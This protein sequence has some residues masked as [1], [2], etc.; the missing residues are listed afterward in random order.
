MT[1]AIPFL[2]TISPA[3]VEDEPLLLQIQSG[4]LQAHA[5]MELP[6]SLRRLGQRMLNE[7]L[8]LDAEELDTIGR[9]LGRALFI[10]RVRDLLLECAKVVAQNEQ[11][12]QIQL[13]INKPEIAALPWEYMT[14]GAA[15]PW[16]PALRDDYTLVRIGRQSP[17]PAPISVVGPL[18]ILA[19]GGPGQ[20]EQLAE[21]RAAL[22]D[23]IQERLISLR[24]LADTD[25]EEVERVLTREQFHIVHCASDVTLSEQGIDVAL[26]PGITGFDFADILSTHMTLRLLTLTGQSGKPNS[27][28]AIPLMLGAISMS[29]DI[30]AA[31]ALAGPLDNEATALFSATCYREIAA[32]EPLDLAVAVGRRALAEGQQAPWGMAQLRMLPGADRLFH[33]QAAPPR[34]SPR[35]LLPFAIIALLLVGIFLFGRMFSSAFQAPQ[36]IRPLGT[37]QPG[38]LVTSTAGGF[39][40]PLI[41]GAPA[42]PTASPTAL[43]LPQPQGYTVYTVAMSDTLESIATRFG[44]NVRGIAELNGLPSNRPLRIEQA[45]AIPVYQQGTIEPGGVIVRKGDLTRARVALTFDVE[46]DDKSIYSMLETLRAQGMKGTF[47]VTGNWV[48]AFPDAARAIIRDGHE[49]GNHS[50]PHP[51]VSRIGYDVAAS[52]LE[53]TEQLVRENTAA[54]TR[55]PFRSPYGD[56]T[57]AMV[58]LAGARGFVAYHWTCDDPA[59]PTWLAQA[60]SNPASANGAI[61]LFH[62]RTE[63][64]AQLAGWLERLKALGIEA[65]TLTEAMR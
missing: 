63:T 48:R 51:Y 18:R 5:E 21:L 52:E 23:A 8:V 46:I 58:L 2:I 54:S 60:E 55:P 6:G 42:T 30:P 7:Q 61:L 35:R 31:L 43:P 25:L 37:L 49:L 27:L 47:F 20:R 12:L 24:I 17:P 53:Q 3:L 4:D 16:I 38:T 29:D 33:F 34:L 22:A 65:T 41:P 45:L 40:I 64:A 10:P 28:S 62:G 39:K 11:R 32:G 13:Q 56:S 1:Q 50:L 26:G 19:I 15:K 59:F 9:Q 14:I 36:P 57:P 44:S